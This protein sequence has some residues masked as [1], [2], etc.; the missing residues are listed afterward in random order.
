MVSQYH[1]DSGQKIRDTVFLPNF[2]Y[3]PG[4]F[5]G[6]VGE[7]SRKSAKIS[8]KNQATERAGQCSTG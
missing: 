8:L 3:Y 6:F 5:I 7:I 2:E 1:I 4:N